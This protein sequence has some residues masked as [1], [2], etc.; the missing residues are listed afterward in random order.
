MTSS[1]DVPIPGLAP[2]FTLRLDP[3]GGARIGQLATGGVREHRA[4]SGGRLQGERLSGDLLPDHSGET[5]LR[6]TDGVAAVEA[7]YLVRTGEGQVLRLL[8]TGYATGT[9]DFAGVRMTIVIEV[10]EAGPH[11]WASRRAFVA[12][13]P[14]GSD[15]LQIAE[16]V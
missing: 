14:A 12:E 15:A 1:D 10:D 9:G 2:A 5:W 11:A 13:R 6:R 8:G 7:A 16:V 3:A 4:F